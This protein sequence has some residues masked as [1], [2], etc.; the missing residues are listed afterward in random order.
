MLVS[1]NFKS[2]IQIDNR[3]QASS[4]IAKPKRDEETSHK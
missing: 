1:M 4:G 3:L 2:H